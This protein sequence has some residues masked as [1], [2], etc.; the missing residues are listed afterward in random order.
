VDTTLSSPV[1]K[2]NAVVAPASANSYTNSS[3]SEESGSVKGPWEPVGSPKIILKDMADDDD[4][5]PTDPRSSFYRNSRKE[6]HRTVLVYNSRSEVI[7]TNWVTETVDYRTGKTTYRSVSHL[8]DPTPPTQVVVVEQPCCDP[9]PCCGG[10]S[11][12][13]QYYSGGYHSGGSWSGNSFP[14][15]AYGGQYYSG[16]YN[17]GNYRAGERWSTSGYG[18]SSSSGNWFSAGGGFGGTVYPRNVRTYERTYSWGFGTSVGAGV[19]SGLSRGGGN[20][21]SGSTY[22]R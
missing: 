18:N 13:G 10:N 8:A 12:G 7:G 2:T 11:Y 19:S 9:Q 6:L 14:G 4:A 16:G 20:F 3:A 21:S 22:S 5:P 15:S 1:T 17:A